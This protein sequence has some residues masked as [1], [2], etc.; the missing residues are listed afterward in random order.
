LRRRVEPQDRR[1][2][3]FFHPQLR[4][5]PLIFVEVA[6]TRGVPGAIAPLLSENRKPVPQDAATTAVF[7]S[8]SNC[9]EG[10]RGISF[11]NFLIKQVVEDLRRQLPNLT[12]FVTLSPAPGFAR[13][14]DREMEGLSEAERAALAP[15]S[16]PGWHDDA[17]LAAQV[18]PVLLA[19]AARYFL[20]ATAESG[21]PVDPV[22]RFHLGNGARL[23]RLDPLG[24]LSAK[25][26]RDSHGLMVNYLYDLD[27]IE[28]N[29][30]AYAASGRVVA[31]SAVRS[32]LP[33]ERR[34]AGRFPSL[35]LSGGQ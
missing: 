15:L 11:G 7:Y 24:D 2:F 33:V 28:K 8:I 34:R 17:A 32:Y 23:E 25:G 13:W 31:S 3:A 5:E 29:H 6:L 10:L 30:E 19:Q 35:S 27:H 20:E 18:R 4:D 1:L 22:A 12:T 14:L 9:Q 21:K 16:E 26:L